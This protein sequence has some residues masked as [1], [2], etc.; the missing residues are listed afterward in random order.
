MTHVDVVEVTPVEAITTTVLGTQHVIETA[1]DA[2]VDRV[3]LTS[4][5]A[6]VESANTMEM[7][8]VAVKPLKWYL[9]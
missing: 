7:G 1:I 3:L 4:S 6:A 9:A 8:S 5:D 2:G